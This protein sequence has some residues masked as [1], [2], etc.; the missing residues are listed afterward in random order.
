[1]TSMQDEDNSAMAQGA[2]DRALASTADLLAIALEY[3]RAGHH[4]D[5][6]ETY[7]QILDLE[8]DHFLFLHHLGLIAHHRGEHAAAA[9]LISR[10]IEIKPDY[11]EALSNL[12]AIFRSM[13]KTEEAIDATQ[14]AIALQPDFAQ[15]HSNWPAPMG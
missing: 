15:A 10:A 9:K 1:M 7:T 14:K 12:G 6:E 13:G 8:P 5:A 2:P 3:F 11:V 4:R